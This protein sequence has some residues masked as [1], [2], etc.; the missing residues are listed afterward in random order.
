M[1]PSE[2]TSAGTDLL[3][4]LIKSE[5]RIREAAGDDNRVKALEDEV[6]RLALEV[7]EHA[8][9]Y[10]LIVA[11]PDFAMSKVHA[12]PKSLFLSGGEELINKVEELAGHSDFEIFDSARRGDHAQER[13]NQLSSASAAVFDVGVPAGADR[14]QVCYELGL[15]VALGK[16]S[17]VV[18]RPKQKLPFDI[19]LPP[20]HIDYKLKADAGLLD[21]AIELALGNVV[22]GGGEAGLG[23]GPRE[24]LAWLDRN[25]HGRLSEG[26]LRIAMGLTESKQ[27]DAI[28]FRRSLEQLLG[29]LGADAPAVLLPAWPPAY[30]DPAIQPRCFHVMP[31]RPKW[32]KPTRN[33]AEAVCTEKNW[34]YSRG[35][36][37]EEQ[38][39]IHGIWSEIAR[40][41]GVLIDITGHNPNVALELGLVHALG[42]PYRI[43]AQGSAEKHSFMSLE[44]VQVHSYGRG[45]G[46]K[47]FEKTVADLLESSL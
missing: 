7:Q 37:A 46:Y 33:L 35:D 44:K 28:A 21:Q 20:V 19:N 11:H 1:L 47:G 29:M 34:H 16:P 32:A 42:R 9:R 30:P 27:D 8:R 5:A 17:V 39:I 41:S 3:M 36:E 24:A 12:R 45:P 18:A 14:A 6:W 25:F 38:R 40:S 23:Q 31:F 10:H 4:R 15:G 26:S 22:W 2:E 13:W 43:V